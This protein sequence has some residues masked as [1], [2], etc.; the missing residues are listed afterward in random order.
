MTEKE[1][2]L[3]GEIYSADEPKLLEELAAA[4]EVMHDYNT[5]RATENQKK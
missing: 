5:L 3:A 4:R 2:M 1:K